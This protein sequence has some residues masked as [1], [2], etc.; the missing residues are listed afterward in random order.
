MEAVW[1]R[2]ER[3]IVR[4]AKG[5]KGRNGSCP[6]ISCSELKLSAGTTCAH[7]SGRDEGREGEGREGR[8]LERAVF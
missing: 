7:V 6:C 2:K 3:R 5:G 8:A 4:G 1:G